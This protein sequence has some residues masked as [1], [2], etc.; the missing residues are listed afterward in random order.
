MIVKTVLSLA[1]L[2]PAC[3]GLLPSH[4]ASQPDP[5]PPS[6]LLRLEQ[7][8]FLDSLAFVY[9]PSLWVSYQDSL[10]FAPKTDAQERRL[11]TLRAE[12]SRYRAFQDPRAWHDL[13]A[14]VL[15]NSGLSPAW[16]QKLLNAY[17]PTNPVLTPVLRKPLRIVSRYELE[18]EPKDGDAVLRADG[19]RLF[20]LNF[21]RG[22]QDAFHT[23]AFLIKEGTKS[24]M[25]DK[26]DLERL[27]AF[28][29]A[30]LTGEEQKILRAA[31]AAFRNAAAALGEAPATPQQRQEFELL[32][33]R[34]TDESPSRQ[35]EVAKAYLEGI[36]T[37]K[38]E[39]TGMQW[40]RKAAA[41][42]SGEAQAFLEKRN[43]APKER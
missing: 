28:S 42:G 34:A 31:S 8:H 33:A 13:A 27:E 30:A 7:R 16:R 25:S 14:K 43:S 40:M 35:Y 41:N 26:G 18:A 1:V 5:A 36:G 12:R 11:D 23:N 15:A 19:Q 22:T 37:E 38:D 2:L 21:G 32:V 17:S 10:L 6:A 29:N 39:S 4:A 24:F 20:V 9:D 3:L